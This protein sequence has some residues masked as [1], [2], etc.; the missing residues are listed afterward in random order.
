VGKLKCPHCGHDFEADESDENE[1][2]ARHE[3]IKS[4]VRDINA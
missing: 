2:I 1:K 4:M 3:F